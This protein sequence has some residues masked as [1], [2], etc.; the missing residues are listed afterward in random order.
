MQGV[1]YNTSLFRLNCVLNIKHG[2]NTMFFNK[3]Y[4]AGLKITK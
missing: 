2:K 4:D 1:Y 3:K